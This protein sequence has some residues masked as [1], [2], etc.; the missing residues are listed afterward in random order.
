[1][2]PG[3]PKLDKKSDTVRMSFSCTEVEAAKLRA[4]AQ[5][6]GIKVSEL[7]RLA[8]QEYQARMRGE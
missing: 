1:M 8:W 6:L 2:K 5:I 3:R 4:T 7:I